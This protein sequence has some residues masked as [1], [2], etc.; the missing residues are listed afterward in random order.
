M[1][2]DLVESRVFFARGNAYPPPC[3]SVGNK[4]GEARVSVKRWQCYHHQYVSRSYVLGP[5]RTIHAATHT[6]KRARRLLHSALII[7]RLPFWCDHSDARRRSLVLFWYLPRSTCS[8]LTTW[9]CSTGFRRIDSL[10]EIFRIHFC[11]LWLHTFT[12]NYLDKTYLLYI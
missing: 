4:D 8:F 9:T 1:N 2:L 11:N 3:A 7:C 12:Y 6:R 10:S 5:I